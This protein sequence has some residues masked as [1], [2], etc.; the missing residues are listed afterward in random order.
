MVIKKSAAKPPFSP[1]RIMWR[2]LKRTK[3]QFSRCDGGLHNPTAFPKISPWKIPRKVPLKHF[4]KLVKSPKTLFKKS[5]E[6]FFNHPKDS[7]IDISIYIHRTGR[8]QKKW[9]CYYS[10][11][12]LE[13]TRILDDEWLRISK[14]LLMK[15]YQIPIKLGSSERNQ[16]YFGN[17]WYFWGCVCIASCSI[18]TDSFLLT[19]F[20]DLSYVG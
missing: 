16:C 17:P 3:R 5:R 9:G 13:S 4:Q 14:S 2:S 18:L 7:K 11:T 12:W 19:L 8:S 1:A 6:Q 15:K 10:N 20:G